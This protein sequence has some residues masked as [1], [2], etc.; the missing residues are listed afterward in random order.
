MKMCS[1]LHA[2]CTETIKIF[3]KFEKKDNGEKF[4]F[5]EK[6]CHLSTLEL[7]LRA[8]SNVHQEHNMLW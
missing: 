2:Y 4:S 1:L 6:K 5:I 8:N 3:K 7:P